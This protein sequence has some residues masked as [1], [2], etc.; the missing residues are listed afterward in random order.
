MSRHSWGD[1]VRPDLNN[2]FRSCKKCGL[3]RITRHEDD[4]NPRHWIEFELEGRK[5][6]TAKTPICEAV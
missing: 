2:T 3:V 5:I 4:N 6:T 1:P